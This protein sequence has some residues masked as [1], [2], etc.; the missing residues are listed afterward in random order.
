MF[1]AIHIS[2]KYNNRN[3]LNALNSIL[4]CAQYVEVTYVLPIY[5]HVN[6]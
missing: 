3:L 1:I 6:A 4:L 5:V 2:G